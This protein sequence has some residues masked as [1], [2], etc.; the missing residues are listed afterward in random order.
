MSMICLFAVP[1]VA[2]IAATAN[3]IVPLLLGPNWLS[4]IPILQ[5]LAFFGISQVMLSNA[6]ALFLALGRA[7]IF[8]RLNGA[9]VVVLI[10]L[11]IVFVGYGGATGAAYA[12]L[13]SAL[14]ILP[15]A[16][17][18]IIRVL[19]LAVRRFVA[20]VWR[21]LAAATVMY[22]AVAQYSSS[23]PPT[24]S[25]LELASTMAVSV[26]LGVGIYVSAIALFW[27]L[28]G[29]PAS[30]ETAALKQLQSLLRRGLAMVRGGAS[31]DPK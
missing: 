8:A 12:Y 14:V 28:S 17:L 18:V 22:F 16:V 20:A 30:A 7:S 21:P 31:A 5:V 27:A 11:L 23:R 29:R 4:A 25:V 1:A 15:F 6:Y 24:A 3:L 13:T 9:L 26:L 10:A 2:G 19:Q